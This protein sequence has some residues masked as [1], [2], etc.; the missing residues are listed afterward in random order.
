[1]KR[2]FF[3]LTCLIVTASLFA[4][5]GGQSSGSSAAPR[6]AS[7]GR[8]Y[9]SLPLSDGKTAFS[10]FVSGVGDYG[11]LT[12]F[13]Y[14]DNTYT[15][16]I[17]DDTG[18]NLNFIGVSTLE[19]N[20]R[21]S[22]MLNSGDY[23]DLIINNISLND[24]LYYAQQKIFIPLDD[25]H[26][27]EYPNIA[28]TFN[29]YPALNTRLRGTDGK[30]YALPWV[31]DCIHCIYQAGRTWYYM[32]WVRD[33]NRKSPTTLD[34]FTA[35]LTWIRDNDV[36]G[37]GN[38]NDEIPWAFSSNDLDNV[39]SY[40][41]KAY[42]PWVWGGLARYD[43]VVT[44]QYRLNE[45]REVLRYLNSLYKEG[46]IKEDSFTMN[47][48]QLKALISNPTPIVGVYGTA[49]ADYTTGGWAGN[50]RAIESL[51]LPMLKGPTGQRWGANNDPWSI[52]ST[53]L[54]VT[55]KCKDPE[56]AVALYNYMIDYTIMLE[57]LGQKGE[58]WDA[59]DPG[60]LNL[61]GGSALYKY[62]SGW[63]QPVNHTSVQQFPFVRDLTFRQ[64]QQATN[65]KPVLDWMATGDPKLLP[66]LLK[67][68][69]YQEIFYNNFPAVQK[70][71]TIPEKYFIPPI[72]MSEIDTNRVSDINAVLTSYK[73]QAWAEFITGIKNINNNT[74]WNNYLA[75][76]DRIGSKDLVS[77]TQKYVK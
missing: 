52:L 77:I 64:G 34:E 60:A 25:Y 30:L 16:K 67:D 28:R 13:D 23:P 5:G 21:M 33:N 76:L 19:K 15:K 11:M 56:L 6:G 38:R 50:Q 46:L 58:G 74:D 14:K 40:I 49:W 31:N 63:K 27:M 57:D 44:E 53:G 8:K 3:I 47:G 65:P 73:K 51:I 37:N 68:T 18:V 24:L 1:M 9:S 59:A 7:A 54:I 2:P 35:Y 48:D 26:V 43:G 61:V 69:E 66:G 39:I 29:S 12:S 70:D 41:A 22:I 71:I 20:E 36:N 45:F 10:V 42:M 55:N 62:I 32:P 4:A 17:V 72:A 75:D